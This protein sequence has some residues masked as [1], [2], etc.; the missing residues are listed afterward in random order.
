MASRGNPAARG[1][2]VSRR[3]GANRLFVSFRCLLERFI[4]RHFRTIRLVRAAAVRAPRAPRPRSSLVTAVR[5]AVR[6]SAAAEPR[7]RYWPCKRNSQSIRAP[8]FQSV[9]WCS[10]GV[11]VCGGTTSPG[12]INGSSDIHPLLTQLLSPRTPRFKGGIA[13]MPRSASDQAC[14]AWWTCLVLVWLV[15]VGLDVAAIKRGRGVERARGDCDPVDC[16]VRLIRWC[17]GAFAV[18]DEHQGDQGR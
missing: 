13:G 4:D 14:R 9:H 12:L 16:D 6:R 10:P 8:S 5:A 2:A 18:V 7:H 15:E 11:G 17:V 3:G 1:H